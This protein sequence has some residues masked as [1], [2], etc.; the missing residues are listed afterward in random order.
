MGLETLWRVTMIPNRKP[1][2]SLTVKD[3]VKILESAVD[4]VKELSMRWIRNC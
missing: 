1:S 4:N 3:K 2:Y